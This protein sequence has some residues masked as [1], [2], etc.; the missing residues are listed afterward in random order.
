[1]M[2][3]IK[4]SD[5]NENMGVL[6]D[7]SNSSDYA[8]S[9]DSRARNIPYQKLLLH[10]RE[11]LDFNTPYYLLCSKGIHSSKAVALLEYFGYD[12]TQVIY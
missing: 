3:R 11:Y 7:L 2:K 8:Y 9:H 1:M 10:Y 12:V 5:Y 4:L 6:I